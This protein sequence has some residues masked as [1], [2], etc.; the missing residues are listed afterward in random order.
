VCALLHQVRMTQAPEF[1]SSLPI[2]V[3][4]PLAEPGMFITI[5]RFPDDSSCDDVGSESMAPTNRNSQKNLR[6]TSSSE[7]G[8]HWQ[9]ARMG[10]NQSEI[11]ANALSTTARVPDPRGGVQSH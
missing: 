2:G 1:S 8:P 11:S 10:S 3:S 5:A 6:A 9:V 7:A 4:Q